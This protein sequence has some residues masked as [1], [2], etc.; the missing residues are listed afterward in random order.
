MELHQNVTVVPLIMPHRVQTRI[1]VFSESCNQQSNSKR[2]LWKRRDY[3][4][5][6]HFVPGLH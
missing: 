5:R 2:Q 3:L 4:F 1:T 6:A